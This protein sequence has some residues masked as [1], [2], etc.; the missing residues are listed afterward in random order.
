[1]QRKQN[2]FGVKYGT[3]KSMTERLNGYLIIKK[4]LEGLEAGPEVDINLEHLNSSEL[5]NAWLWCCTWIL[6][7]KIHVHP[8]Q[9]TFSNEKLLKRT[10]I[11]ERTAMR[12]S[13][14]I[15]KEP[16]KGITEQYYVNL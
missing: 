2:R 5:E 9:S 16:Q 8:E 4:R 1:M 11:P 7:D 12:K 13:I 14:L 6:L 15:Q 10:N 3:R